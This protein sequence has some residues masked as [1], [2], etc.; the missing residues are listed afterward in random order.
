LSPSVYSGPGGLHHHGQPR[1]AS[2][3]SLSQ[4]YRYCK[5]A[6]RTVFAVVFSRKL[7]WKLFLPH[8]S[9]KF[10]IGFAIKS[11]YI[12]RYSKF[13]WPKVYV[14]FSKK[15]K[16]SIFTKCF[17]ENTKREYFHSNDII[18]FNPH[19]PPPPIVTKTHNLFKFCF[20]LYLKAHNLS[21]LI[22]TLKTLLW[23]QCIRTV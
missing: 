13:F 4:C 15:H 19:L 11:T 8:F 5:N 7:T 1:P 10:L 22:R 9:H 2:P 16:Q 21:L 6:Q 17:Q 23:P 18:V 20:F 3:T 12:F 14:L